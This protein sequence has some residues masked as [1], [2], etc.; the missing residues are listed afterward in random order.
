MKVFYEF[1]DSISYEIQF[2]IPDA[3]TKCFISQRIK[4]FKEE[5]PG[6]YDLAFE[7]DFSARLKFSLTF[8]NAVEQTMLILKWS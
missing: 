8:K 2:E 4:Q 1:I 5:N 7:F 6:D 3:K